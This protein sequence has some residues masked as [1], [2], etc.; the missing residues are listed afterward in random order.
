MT[1]DKQIIDKRDDGFISICANFKEPNCLAP[2]ATEN[3]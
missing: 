2:I 1:A 3:P